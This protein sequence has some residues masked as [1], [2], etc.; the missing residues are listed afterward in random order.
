MAKLTPRVCALLLLSGWA[1]SDQIS[2][3]KF[4]GLNNQSSSVIID[5]TEASDLLNV[6]VTPTGQSVKKRSGY[7]V[8]KALS[9]AKPMH[10]GFHSFDTTGNDVQIWGSSTSLYGIVG[11]ATPTQLVSSATLNSTWDCADSQGSSYCVD[12]NRD[13]YIKTSGATINWYTS[14]LGTMVESTPDRMV[15]A[16]VSGSPNTLYVSQSNTFTNFTTGINTTDAFTEVIASPGSKLTHIRWGCGKLLWWKDQSFGYFDFDNQYAAQVRTVSDTIGTFDN[17]SAID[18]GGR[19]WFRGQ[20]GHTWMYDCSSL[21][22]ESIDITPNV[23]ASGS[24]VSNLWTQS[25]QSEFQTG[26]IVPT[27]NL[28][29]TI[30]AGD[31]IVSSF[32]AIENSSAQWVNGSVSNLT[33]NPSSITFNTNNSGSINDPN[34]EGTFSTNFVSDVSPPIFDTTE[35]GSACTLNP[36]SGSQFL[37]LEPASI[38][39][40]CNNTYGVRLLNQNGAILDSKSTSAS[41]NACAWTN[42]TFT[43]PSY[44][45]KRVKFAF[46]E[47]GD[48]CV[49]SSFVRIA[50]TTASYIF[51][52][53]I[54]YYYSC[55]CGTVGCDRLWCS[56]DNVSLGSSTITTGSFTSQIYDTGFT[57]STFQ[58]SGFNWTANT[59]TPTFSLATS[60][61][62]TG[63][64][65]T[66]LTSSGTN[67]VGNRYAQYSSTISIS[68]SD[69]ALTYIS[70]VTILSRSTGTYYSSV[71]NAPNLISWSTFGANQTLNSGTE[72]FYIRASTNS[73]TVLSSTPAWV[74]QNVGGLVSASTGTYFQVR[75]DFALTAATQAVTLNDFTVNWFEGTATDQAYMRYFDNAIWESVAFGAG[76]STNNY[77]FKY[78]LINDAWT[79]YN[80]GAGGLLVQANTLYFG[81]TSAGNV[82]NYGTATSDNGTAINAYWKSKV[83]TG[84]DPFL[85]TA[86]TNIDTFAAKN[87]GTT[88]TATYTLDT[89]TS[90]SYSISLSTSASIIQ[91]RKLLPSGKNAYGFSL[92]YGDTSA[93]SAWELFGYRIGF[94]ALAYR[95]SNP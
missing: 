91:N 32:Q 24:R 12:S 71:K 83:F 47:I 64:F 10:G 72:T 53:S 35:A 26:S 27:A 3:T 30:S 21:A 63:P 74:A 75:D 70:S 5:P 76:Q 15:V 2:S 17:T 89:S 94:N 92:Q 8:Y 65:T 18:P 31:V 48:N 38:T 11:G 28:S 42:E 40:N 62:S 23:Q 22:K 68:S 61:G 84:S 66:L 20:D 34:F 29:T 39:K 95:P 45:G 49:G 41:N 7:G 57:S 81:D 77:I 88:L 67:A 43:S 90:T 25:S 1:F 51:G 19:V 16:G 9:T 6:D 73:F 54:S 14:P 80:F 58:I 13:A 33:V 36:Q 69:N 85:Q 52:G 59:S 37:E 4:K 78:D 44:T 82:F 55:N 86:L 56:F 93:S 60:T 50:T 87:Q 46:F 79:L